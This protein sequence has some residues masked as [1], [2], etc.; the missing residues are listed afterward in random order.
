MIWRSCHQVLAFLAAFPTARAANDACL[1]DSTA[2]LQLRM[3]RGSQI[4]AIKPDDVMKA[5]PGLSSSPSPSFADEV[6]FWEQTGGK[7]GR[8][9]DAVGGQAIQATHHMVNQVKLEQVAGVGILARATYQVME[10]FRQC[11]RNVV[12]GLKS[13]AMALFTLA[14]MLENSVDQTAVQVEER[15]VNAD[16]N[17]G[18][19]EAEIKSEDQ[20]EFKADEEK[21]KESLTEDV[22]HDEMI[23][24]LDEKPAPDV[25]GE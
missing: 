22:M 12:Q 5:M 9:V 11:V 19:I 2:L 24:A 6:H 18:A 16:A 20:A 17:S 10:F 3:E 7:V 15:A 13:A 25:P 23:K 4:P 8:M 14:H 1:A 21:L